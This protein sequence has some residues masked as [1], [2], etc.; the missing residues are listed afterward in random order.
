M[1]SEAYKIIPKA[2]CRFRGLWLASG[3]ELD[4]ATQHLVIVFAARLQG[5]NPFDSSRA[6]L[7]NYLYLLTR[8]VLS[9]QA[10]R[11][12]NRNQ[13]LGAIAPIELHR[14]EVLQEDLLVPPRSTRDWDDDHWDHGPLDGPPGSEWRLLQDCRR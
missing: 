13:T 3:L 6:T 9:N 5:Q 8:S 14:H 7:K 12:K 1:I 4:D 2:I 11:R 10:E